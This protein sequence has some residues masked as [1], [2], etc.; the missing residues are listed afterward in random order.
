MGCVRCRTSETKD[1][2]KAYLCSD[3]GQLVVVDKS[4]AEYTRQG[5]DA[6][7]QFTKNFGFR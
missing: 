4:H 5:T 6:Y 3:I 1:P 7:Q 2:W